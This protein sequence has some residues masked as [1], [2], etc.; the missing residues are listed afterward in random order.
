MQG[1]I[2]TD[3]LLPLAIGIVMLGLG[4]SLT[5]E[6][7]RRVARYP[8]AVGFGLFLQV[9]LL[10]LAA[11]AIAIGLRL[12][13]DHAIGL[14]LL[15]AAPGGATANIYSHLARGDV[16]LNITLTAV[17]SLLCLL[18]L[19][20]VLDLSLGYFLGNGQYVPPPHRKVIE[21]GAIILIPV[22]IG[23]LLRARAE[24]FAIRAEKPIKI[25]SILVLA[26][27]IAGAI[28]IE[29]KALLPSLIAVGGACLA[30]NLV[31]ML[32]GYLAPLALRLPKG[33]AVAIAMEIGIHNAALAIFIAL[34][35]LRNPAAAVVPG[36]YSL[37]M[38]VT[39]SAF[40]IWLVRRN[41]A[42]RPA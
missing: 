24:R 4:L 22:A 19:P 27:L 36:I 28:Y 2:L 25:F 10:P 15:A 20:V 16:A 6:D 42:L 3:L 30:F 31:S 23:M 1:S 35:V 32:T 34:N 14:M 12:S 39:A 5:I 8:L 38:Y 11:F 7:F 37:V 40:A 41:T 9:L 29:R 21:V 18:T 33:Q 17:N 26:V 13:A